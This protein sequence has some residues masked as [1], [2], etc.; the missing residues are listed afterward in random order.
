MDKYAVS[1]N[2]AFK[3]A[4]LPAVSFDDVTSGRYPV[5]GT[6]PHCGRGPS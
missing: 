5:K 4:R 3:V 1:A 6:C 2:M